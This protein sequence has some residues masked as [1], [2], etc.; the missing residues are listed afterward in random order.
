MERQ[1]KR[2]DILVPLGG[3]GGVETVIN[4]TALFLQDKGYH[5]RIVQWTSDGYCWPD[6]AIPYYPLLLNQKLDTIYDAIPLYVSFL[7]ENG[8]PDMVL[9][10]PWPYMSVVA[11]EALRCMGVSGCVISWLHGPMKKYIQYGAGGYGSLTYADSCFVLNRKEAERIR[12]NLSELKVTVVHNP[13]DFS[14]CVYHEE[15]PE[16]KKTLLFVG[17]LSAEKR[18]QFILESMVN[19]SHE[20]RLRIVGDGDERDRLQQMAVELGLETRVEFLGWQK[21]PWEYAKDV[22]ALVLASEYEGAPLV[23]Y[24]ALA[25]GVPVISP[26]LDACVELI[27]PGYNGFLYSADMGLDLSVVLDLYG[28]G[29]FPEILSRNC[30]DSVME[31][32]EESALQDFLLKLQEVWE[33]NAVCL[34]EGC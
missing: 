5:M 16:H 10:A 18:I 24:E 13:V 2:I 22:S 7:K 15:Q 26:P 20:W 19:A 4:R 30:R 17:R 34:G 6:S 9:A 23:V 14:A 1:L 21:N 28:E 11:K 29:Q 31:Y 8:V 32:R 33:E 3:V 27:Q 25:C 12:A